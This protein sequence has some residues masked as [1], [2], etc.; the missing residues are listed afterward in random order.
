[1]CQ[2]PHALPVF[3][4]VQGLVCVRVC[5]MSASCVQPLMFV[6]LIVFTGRL[7][8]LRVAVNDESAHLLVCPQFSSVSSYLR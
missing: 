6:K 5:A 2:A 3:V 8:L 4:I 1:M 7:V